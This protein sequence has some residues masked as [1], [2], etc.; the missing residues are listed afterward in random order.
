MWAVENLQTHFG[1]TSSGDISISSRSRDYISVLLKGLQLIYTEERWR[2][3]VFELLL[4]KLEP[5]IDLKLGRP[6]M[7][8]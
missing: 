5:E 4:E 1:K 8:R 7:N 6:S 2:Q 3:R